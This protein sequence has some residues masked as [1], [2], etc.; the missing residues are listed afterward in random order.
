[1][2][3][4]GCEQTSVS[5]VCVE[6]VRDETYYMRDGSCVL[7]VENTLFNVHRTLLSKDSSLFS[8]MLELPQGDK[9]AEGSSDSCPIH[10]N[11]E[12][13]VEFKNFLWVLYALPHEVCLVTSPQMDLER[14]SRLI[15]ITRISFK[16]HF[17]SIE[18]WS[19]DVITEHTSV[20]AT[21]IASTTMNAHSAVVTTP[22]AIASNGAL[23]S[24][25]MR[26]AQLC[27]HE[28]L[29]STMISVLRQLMSCSIR[30]AHLAM[31]LAD[32]LDLRSLRGVAYFEVMQKSNAVVARGNS[33]GEDDHGNDID[34]D[35]RSTMLDS[36]GR[37]IVSHQ[38]K[39]RLLTGYSRLSM[40]GCTQCW[41]EFWKE[42]TKSD[43]VLQHGLADVLGRL[44]AVAKEFGRWRSATYMHTDCR[45]IARKMIQDK[46]K[47]VED[48]LV[49]YFA[50]E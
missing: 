19:L 46:V 14:L 27:G 5:R 9:V 40:H 25:L 6:L 20:T 31:T 28:K 18:T 4:G 12:N 49:D 39:S 23:V 16:Y 42:K 50:D 36:E 35:A 22:Q 33:R 34:K 1:M 15:D 13:V 3:G 30:Y 24:R 2:V 11:G 17:K 32:G 26:L 21:S 47:I 48:S 41:L 45:A 37:L 10:L 44:R 7:Q 29:L 8:S 38:Q 43:S